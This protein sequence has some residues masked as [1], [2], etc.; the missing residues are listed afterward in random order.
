MSIFMS[1]IPTA[2]QH[3]MKNQ[4][5]N[6]ALIHTRGDFSLGFSVPVQMLRWQQITHQQLLVSAYLN[7]HADHGILTTLTSRKPSWIQGD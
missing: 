2:L 7:D 1:V 3:L 5:R 6:R 4:P